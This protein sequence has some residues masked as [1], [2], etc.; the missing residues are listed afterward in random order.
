MSKTFS[1]VSHY[2]S[3]GPHLVIYFFIFYFCGTTINVIFGKVKSR[4]VVVNTSSEFAVAVKKFVPSISKVYMLA[5]RIIVEPE[6]IENAPS[7]RGTRKIQKIV[8]MFDNGQPYLNFFELTCDDESF[9]AHKC[10]T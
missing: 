3:I 7:I 1:S 4:Y 8:R 6:E 2:F 10:I 5:N 9:C